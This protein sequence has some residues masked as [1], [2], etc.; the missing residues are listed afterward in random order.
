MKTSQLTLIALTALATQSALCEQKK[1]DLAR[2]PVANALYTEYAEPEE[3]ANIERVKVAV[4]TA[5][6]HR[7]AN[8]PKTLR[9]THAKTH[10]CVKAN[11]TVNDNIP[12]KYKVGLFSKPTTYKTWLRFANGRGGVEADST[13][14]T[15]SMSVKIM[16][17]EG[18][19]LN[20]ASEARTQDI[21]TQNAP[22]FFI[23]S[24][25]QYADFFEHAAKGEQSVKLWFLN[26]LHLHETLTLKQMTSSF[27]SSLLE[28]KYWSGSAF[29]LGTPPHHIAVKYVFSPCTK[30][31]VKAPEN[32]PA[33]YYR[34]ELVNH[35]ATQSSC[36][37]FALQEQTNKSMPIDDLTFEWSETESPLVI[38]GKMTIE[39][40]SIDSPAQ[41]NF[42]ENLSF[43][44]WNAKVEHKPIGALN[45]LRKEIYPM[46]SAYR[47][48][49]NGVP[50]SEPTGD[51]Q[52]SKKSLSNDVPY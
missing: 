16:G 46:V 6:Q 18:E 19:R 31:S 50:S 29:Q 39:P 33:T 12:E 21:V 1:F 3:A 17:V 25:A 4:Q 37:N 41:D 27:P 14:D 8:A 48:Q 11:F 43:S 32:L 13:G 20:G 9:D 47:H 45:R 2:P 34:D 40:Q 36:W 7:Y 22:V 51:E 49:K 52:F 26:P 15:R 42:C 24:I 10:G 35:L 38:V 44:P 28:E 23:R 5:L 30:S